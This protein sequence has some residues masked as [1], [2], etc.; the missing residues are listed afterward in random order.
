MR[1]ELPNS[2]AVVEDWPAMLRTAG[3]IDAHSRSYLVDRPAPLADDVRRWV[4]QDL[5]RHREGLDGLLDADDLSALNRLLDP[6]DPAGI[7]RRP[8]AFLLTAKT[9]HFA[10]RPE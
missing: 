9:V 7:D 6:A 8:D 4:R 5:E 10:R 2:T 3:L 1:A